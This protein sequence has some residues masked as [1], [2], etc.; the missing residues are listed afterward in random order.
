MSWRPRRS[1]HGSGAS[2]ARAPPPGGLRDTVR[3]PDDRSR[4]DTLMAAKLRA[5]GFYRAAVLMLGGVA[6]SVILTWLVRMSTG[7]TTYRHFI[8]ADAILTVGLLAVP[9]AFLVGIGGFDYWFHWAIG[10]PTLPEDHS[11][12][13]AHSW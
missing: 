9:L 11:G 13:G 1:R 10:R 12:H 2:R 3:Q 8:S 7:H 4:G 5:P 6:F